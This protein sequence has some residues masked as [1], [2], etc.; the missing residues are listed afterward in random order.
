MDFCEDCD[1]TMKGVLAFIVLAFVFCLPAFYTNIKRASDGGNT[2][3]NKK[4][5][6]IASILSAGFIRDIRNQS[7]TTIQSGSI[8]LVLHG[9]L[10]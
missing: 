7:K 2:A 3:S 1:K 8:L 4:I 10:L 9:F 5:A 6:I